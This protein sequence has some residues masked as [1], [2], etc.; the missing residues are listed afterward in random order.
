MQYG[1][2]AFPRRAVQDTANSYRKR[3][4]PHYSLLPPH[5]TLLSKLELT[6]EEVEN[7]V[8]KLDEIGSRTAPFTVRL[9]KVS[10]FFPVTPTIY[11]AVEDPKPFEQL[12]QELLTVFP[13]HTPEYEYIPHLTI[14]QK[15]EEQELHDVYG[16]LR[17]MDFA[18]TSK[19]D[20]FH[21]MY[22]LENES[23]TI[24]QTFLLQ[25]S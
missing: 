13:N 1:I 6:D 23:W 12:H 20:R 9:H 19:I 7:A 2:V 17:M 25:G 16:Q 10:H 14:G 4:D 18:L 21:L 11:L 5:I 15:M 8:I 3:Y 24:H 22:Q